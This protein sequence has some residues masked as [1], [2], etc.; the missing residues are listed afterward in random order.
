[1]TVLIIAW[2]VFSQ[3]CVTRVRPVGGD[4]WGYINIKGEFIIE[5][6]FYRCSEFSKE[7]FATVYNEDKEPYH[8][9][10]LQGEIMPIEIKDFVLM[11]VF[12]VK[13]PKGF[14]NGLV[15]L[16]QGKKWG[17]LNTLGQVAIPIQYDK[18]TEFNGGFASAEMGGKFMVLDTEGEEYPVNDASV[19]DVKSFAENLAPYKSSNGKVGFINETGDIA[20]P[21]QYLAVGYFSGGLAWARAVSDK[22]GYIN[23]NGEWIIQPRFEVAKSYDAETDRARI[24]L[25]DKMG[26]VNRQ[27]EV[28]Y[29]EAEDV[30]DFSNGLCW[31]RMSDKIGFF[32]KNGE[33]VIAPQFEAVRDFKNGY[34]AAKM[35]DRWGMI[36]MEGKW[37]IAPS[38]EGIMDMDLVE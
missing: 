5:A 11:S 36:D 22:I 10:N 3:T 20:I 29:I 23:T 35:N 28:L 16:R 1:M 32:N 6:L 37:V 9:I 27:G 25:E 15:P 2:N 18:V 26:F 34:A 38:F 31:G 19:V 12:Y 30:G 21:A 14:S 17:Y 24:R 33:W 7:G 8:I 4:K 13:V